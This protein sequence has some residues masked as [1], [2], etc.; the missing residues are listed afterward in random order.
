MG[1]PALSTIQD[2]KGM[3]SKAE[4]SLMHR[5]NLAKDL[6]TLVTSSGKPRER[7]EGDLVAL[8]TWLR[9]SSS[10]LLVWNKNYNIKPREISAA[11]DGLTSLLAT[12]LE[13][14]PDWRDVLMLALAAVGRGGQGDVGQRIRDEILYVQSHNNAKG[15]MMEEW[16]QKL[17]NNT[18][19]DDVVICQALLAYLEHDLDISFYWQT[20]QL[21]E[22]PIDWYGFRN[23]NS[24]GRKHQQGALGQL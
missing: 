19:P 24:A 4:R 2:I 1:T 12:L 10:R 17:H 18:S 15:G 11:Q 8:L 20:L 23:S 13:Q 14:Q 5:F 22:L 6:L 7:Q 16:H 3:E 9:F 21:G